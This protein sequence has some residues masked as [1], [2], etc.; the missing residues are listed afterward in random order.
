M[1]I[2]VINPNTTASMTDLIGHGA[3]AVSGPGVR[4][5]AVNPSSGPASIESHYD[6]AHATP[7]VLAE[8]S[9]GIAAGAD[10]FVIACFGD[11]G[12]YAARELADVPVVGIAEAAM[13]TAGYLGRSFSV[14]TTLFRTVP[15]IREL[16][17]RYG[18]ASLCAGV[19]ASDVAVL[20]LE[21]DPCALDTLR[22]HCAAALA[23]DQSEIIVLGCAGMT[24]FRASLSADLGV[25][26]VD[27]VGAA[28][29]AIV[30]LVRQGLRTS[31]VGEL[32]P[33][34]EKHVRL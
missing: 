16:T 3:R 13:R 27:G 1:H 28:T 17:H 15:Q 24:M 32:A 11:P 8:V 2:R 33:P 22:K 4:L 21:T 12:L 7:G 19:H 30:G 20:E 10:G 31:K 29:T 6:E 14:V 25:P 23:Q 26:V 34:P 5:D 18:V 9:S